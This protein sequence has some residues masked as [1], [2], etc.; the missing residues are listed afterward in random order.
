ML[1][2]LKYINLLY[3]MIYGQFFSDYY[4]IY[5]KNYRNLVIQLIS[6]SNDLQI[7]NSLLVLDD[8]NAYIII[9][10]ICDK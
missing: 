5:R 7:G 6:V 10:I 4:P 1:F 3:I 2:K 8:F 9:V